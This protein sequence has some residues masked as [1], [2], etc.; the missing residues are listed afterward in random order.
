MTVVILNPSGTVISF[1]GT[2]LVVA[3][4]GVS[5]FSGPEAQAINTKRTAGRREDNFIR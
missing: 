2:M 4:A 1:P 3:A 5:F